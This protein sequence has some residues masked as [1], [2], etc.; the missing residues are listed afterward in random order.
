M[1]TSYR[2]Y[3][4]FM[5]TASGLE[6]DAY[7]LFMSMDDLTGTELA[8]RE[9]DVRAGAQIAARLNAGHAGMTEDE[10]LAEYNANIDSALGA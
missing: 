2:S 10:L 6:K 3:E 8:E 4:A 7:S 5:R 9:D 1:K